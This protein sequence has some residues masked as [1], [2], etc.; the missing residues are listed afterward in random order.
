VVPF[1]VGA[2]SELNG[3]PLALQRRPAVGRKNLPKLSQ[4]RADIYFTA[5][6]VAPLVASSIKAATD[7][8]VLHGRYSELGSAVP[9]WIVVDVVR[10]ESGLLA[11]H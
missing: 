9:N 11:E 2:T 6:P 8:V 5:A 1:G 10:M 4:V 3:H 7:L